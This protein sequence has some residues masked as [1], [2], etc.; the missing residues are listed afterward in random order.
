MQQLQPVHVYGLDRRVAGFCRNSALIL[1]VARHVDVALI[2]PSDAPAGKQ[3]T[4]KF[5]F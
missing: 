1:L 4:I 2:A 3:N 5:Y